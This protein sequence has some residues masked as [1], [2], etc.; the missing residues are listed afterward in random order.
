LASSLALGFPIWLPLPVDVPGFWSA[1][2]HIEAHRAR[3]RPVGLDVLVKHCRCAHL[4]FTLAIRRVLAYNALVTV[5][6][7]WPPR[8]E[9]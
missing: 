5:T 8:D 2:R 9:R 6:V 1:A 7:N 4:L 3:C